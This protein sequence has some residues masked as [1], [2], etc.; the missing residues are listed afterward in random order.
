MEA[1]IHHFKDLQWLHLGGGAGDNPEGDGLSS[2]KHGF[3]NA[4]FTALLCGA[5][6]DERAY[7]SLSEIRSN[8]AWFPAYR[9]E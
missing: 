9:N 3:A 1:A 6:L 7:T 8:G 4:E 2:F 5:I